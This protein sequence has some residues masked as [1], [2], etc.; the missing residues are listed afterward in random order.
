MHTG[1]CIFSVKIFAPHFNA[2]HSAPTMTEALGNKEEAM[3]RPRDI[4][5]LL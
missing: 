1:E 4:G 3:D 5:Q 2:D